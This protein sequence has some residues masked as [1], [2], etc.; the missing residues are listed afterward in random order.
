MRKNEGDGEKFFKKLLFF[1]F[2][3]VTLHRDFAEATRPG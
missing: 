3:A 1:E 2:F